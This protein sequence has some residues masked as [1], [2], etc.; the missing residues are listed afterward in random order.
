MWSHSNRV[1]PDLTNCG[2]YVQNKLLA[3][4]K[5][6]IYLGATID[7]SLSFA[8]QG[9]KIKGMSQNKMA[10]LKF[11]RKSVD[12]STSILVYKQMIRPIM[13]YS[14]FLLDGAPEWV[15]RKLQVI[16]NDCLR[17]CVRA[18]D[19]REVSI[20]ELH[21]E[22][23]IDKLETRRNKFLLALM[24]QRSQNEQNTVLPVREL[25]SSSSIKLKVSRP[26]CELYRRSPLFRG[27]S[28]WDGL[29]AKQHHKMS[30]HL[31]MSS[32]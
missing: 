8:G 25:R 12:K 19:V 15:P 28:L 2:L 13:E 3:T 23:E 24:Y 7:Y 1:N 20:D 30:K 6:F 9:R 11:I 27:A 21:V 26:K 5:S 10:Q 16:Q 29:D 22:C 18:R 14:S 32:L 4:V 31:F 17:I